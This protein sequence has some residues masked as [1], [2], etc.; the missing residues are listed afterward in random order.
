MKIPS[1]FEGKQKKHPN[2]VA[3]VIFFFAI[4][5]VDIILSLYNNTYDE[6]IAMALIGV[7]HSILFVFVFVK[8]RK[9]ILPSVVF[10]LT[11]AIIFFMHIEHG[12]GEGSY[13]YLFPAVFGYIT[14]SMTSG[15]KIRFQMFHLV[16]F[17]VVVTMIIQYFISPSNIGNTADTPLY[18]YRLAASFII[19]ARLTSYSLWSKT[20]NQKQ[21]KKATFQDALFQSYRDAYIIFDKET[22][23]VKD[24][25]NRIVQIL[26][27]P[28][29]VNL[30]TLY[31]SQVLMRYLADNSPNLELLMNNIPDEWGGDAIFITYSK[32]KFDAYVKSFTFENDGIQYQLISIRDITEITKAKEELDIY[33]EKMEKAA[34]AKARFLSSMSHELRTPLNG[35]IGTSN[36]IL[37]EKGLPENIKNHI[38]I[39]RYSSEHMLGIINDILDFSKIDAGKLELKRNTFNIKES[40]E[41]LT[42]SFTNEFNNKKIELVFTHDPRIAG[43]NVVSDQ[44][45]LNQVIAN[46]LSN[47]L[48]FTIAGRVVLNVTIDNLTE[49]Q[50]T[51]LFEVQDTGI[52][53]SKEKHEEIFQDFVQVNHGDLR[54]FDGTG[55]GLTISEKLVSIFGGKLQV[56]SELE[57]GSRFYFTIS[58]DL[59][60]EKQVIKKEIINNGLPPDIRG[61]RVLVVEDNEINAGILKSFLLKWKI[62]IKDARNGVHALELLKYHKFDLIL[63]DLEMPEMDGHTALKKIRETD[64][65]IPVIAFT[66]ALLENMDSLITESGFNDYVLKPFHPADLK[67]KIEYY[68]PHRKIEYI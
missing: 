35:I 32:K 30:R 19:A 41:K 34:K 24:Y 45:K 40:L 15:N 14:I 16:V 68:A 8:K 54:S 21:T 36:L 29:T 65:K 53:I 33:K 17:S 27:L 63:M 4:I 6:A 11:A 3:P 51:L 58:L 62:R 66:A 46:L 23:E 59:A 52:G 22:L 57:K 26:D 50:I 55:L 67:K 20:S 48:K 2:F 9:T 13:F 7:L 38:T 43:V 44:V 37:T 31:I 25:N 47:A 64:T 10:F 18:I 28:D 60:P 12:Y 49:K 42:K 61:V 39:L 1:L 5:I 56:E